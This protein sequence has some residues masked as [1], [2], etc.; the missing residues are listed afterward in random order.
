[1]SSQLINTYS[2]YIFAPL[3]FKVA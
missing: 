2:W 1:M 3:A